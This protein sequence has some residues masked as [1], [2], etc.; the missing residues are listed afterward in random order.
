[1]TFDGCV[2]TCGVVSTGILSKVLMDELSIMFRKFNL[3][4]VLSKKHGFYHATSNRLSEEG[5]KKW[6]NFF[7]KGTEKF[8]KLN[9]MLNGFTGSVKNVQEALIIFE[10]TYGL[11]NSSKITINDVINALKEMKMCDKYILAEKLNVGIS[12]MYRYIHLLENA[13]ILRRTTKPQQIES[14]EFFHPTFTRILIEPR[15]RNI[16]FEK[17]FNKLDKGS[18]VKELNISLGTLK[19]WYCGITKI[20][21]DKLRKMLSI[22]N[23]DYQDILGSITKFNRK[24]F[25]FNQNF[26][27]WKVPE[28][29]W[30]SV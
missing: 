28:R 7:E 13:N 1:M 18:I 8:Y 19:N 22:I 2:E 17:L 6:M 21:L 11:T 26:E 24:I 4:M 12:T 20:S 29:P 3:N 10:K 25:C 15:T 9:D 14:L 30:I 27:E 16:M 23:W 5:V